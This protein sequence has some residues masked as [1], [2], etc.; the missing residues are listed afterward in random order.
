MDTS[1]LSEEL[2]SRLNM[3]TLGEY[4]VSPTARNLPSRLSARHVAALIRSRL[5]QVLED[6][7]SV[8]SLAPYEDS[9][10]G[11]DILF[12][13]SLAFG[14]EVGVDGEY[15]RFDDLYTGTAVGRA[16]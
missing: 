8:P 1:G 11:I 9:L 13:L 7:E 16:L 5:V 6:G 3:R 2:S 14:V 12:L 10:C 15:N 4:P